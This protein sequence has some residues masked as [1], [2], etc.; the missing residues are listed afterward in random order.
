MRGWFIE[1]DAKGWTDTRRNRKFNPFSISSSFK[2]VRNHECWSSLPYYTMCMVGG[3]PLRPTGPAP[4][5][6]IPWRIHLYLLTCIFLPFLLLSVLVVDDGQL[7]LLDHRIPT[8]VCLLWSWCKI[9]VCPGILLNW[10]LRCVDKIIISKVFAL[11]WEMDG[12]LETTLPETRR[13]GSCKG[14]H[15]IC[16]H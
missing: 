12:H 10:T 15:G 2:A 14:E 13:V 1:E 16:V 9:C 7:L 3:C 11:P 5:I 6:D 4:Q 8:T